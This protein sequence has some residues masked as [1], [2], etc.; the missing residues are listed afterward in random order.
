MLHVCARWRPGLQS[1]LRE[2]PR[3]QL[4]LQDACNDLELAT[5]IRAAPAFCLYSWRATWRGLSAK[6][7]LLPQPIVVGGTGTGTGSGSGSAALYEC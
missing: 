3:D 7:V 5:A 1:Q 4:C 6:T 2:D